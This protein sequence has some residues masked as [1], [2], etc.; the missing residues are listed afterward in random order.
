MLM[1]KAVRMIAFD[2]IAKNN[3]AN[4]SIVADR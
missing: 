4:A 3:D 1:N 2:R